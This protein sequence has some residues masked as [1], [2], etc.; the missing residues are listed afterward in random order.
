MKV[1][2]F[3]HP[4]IHRMSTA[5]QKEKAKKKRKL[6][7]RDKQLMKVS[8]Q[9]R[10]EKEKAIKEEEERKRRFD[11]NELRRQTIQHNRYKNRKLFVLVDSDKF[12]DRYRKLTG[13]E[14][15]K[16]F[17]CVEPK[18]F[19][20]HVDYLVRCFGMQNKYGK[21]YTFSPFRNSTGLDPLLCRLM[22]EIWDGEEVEKDEEF[23]I[24][25]S[26]V[27]WLVYHDYDF[28]K[29]PARARRY[30]RLLRATPNWACKESIK[31]VYEIRDVMN[32]LCETKNFHVDHVIPLAGEKVCGLH[33]A[34]NLEVIED[35]ENLRKSNKYVL[36]A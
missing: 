17:E 33:V 1:E 16:E 21:A 20:A 23:G 3:V 18:E 6:T 9:A 14:W 15:R 36:E 25:L 29:L 22:K 30:A 26:T 5:I 8:A 4:F 28:S 31:D 10:R 2:C 32:A 12:K 24:S 35:K 11:I 19:V 13:G 27:N 34:G 7:K